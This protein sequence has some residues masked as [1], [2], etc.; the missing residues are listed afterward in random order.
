MRTI[1]SN[2]WEHT[3]EFIHQDKGVVVKRCD[4]AE[5]PD[6]LPP[7]CFIAIP[8]KDC[9]VGFTTED[10]TPSEPKWKRAVY[11]LHRNGQ[12]RPAYF[13]ERIES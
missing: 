12:G 13:F 3:V 8:P 1:E 5:L 2:P 4:L 9:A 7:V 6:P 11:R 10:A